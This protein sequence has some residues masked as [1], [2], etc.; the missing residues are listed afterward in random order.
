MSRSELF[1][2]GAAMITVA[3]ALL[4]GTR[5]MAWILLVF[6]C[7]VIAWPYFLDWKYG[8]YRPTRSEFDLLSVDAH[9]K[10]YRND[11]R[12]AKWINHLYKDQQQNPFNP[13]N[14]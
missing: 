4:I 13:D 2:L 3:L 12:F 8:K 14:F 10:K 5:K 7:A 1:A 6:G 9:K 11:P